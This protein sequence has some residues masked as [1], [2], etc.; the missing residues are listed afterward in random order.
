MRLWGLK[1]SMFLIFS[2]MAHTSEYRRIL[3]RMG[4]Y[5]YQNGL[6]YRHLN[7]DGGWDR[8]LSNCRS[9]IM[10]AVDKASP[11]KISILGSGWLLDL[12][13][14][15]LI[16]RSIKISLVDIV[17]PPEV[18]TQVS[19]YRNVSVLEADVTGGLINEV[20]NKSGN[21]F[22]FKKIFK[23]ELINI[24]EY[25]P[26]ED[27]GMI[28]SL[29]IL[30]QLE[31]LP[32]EFLRKKF[33][34]SEE[35]IRKFKSEVQKKHI[36]FLKKYKT[37]LISDTEEIFHDTDGTEVPE[38]TLLTELPISDNIEEWVW[39]FDLRGGDYYNRRSVMKVV[40]LTMN[41]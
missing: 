5:N 26:D 1:I 41:I 10:K 27:P 18:I 30:T 6:I 4:Y 15:E 36:D 34:V 38:T 11:E 32:V 19:E 29:N 40:A 14:A 8:H 12:P 2:E 24:P 22:L 35:E 21:I 33:K 3:T 17:H 25:F 7:Q 9:F 13:L 23:R 31:A 39:D 16:D 28:I 20:W 37:V